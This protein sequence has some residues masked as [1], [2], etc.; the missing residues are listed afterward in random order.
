MKYPQERI[1]HLDKEIETVMHNLMSFRTRIG[2]VV[3]FGPFIVFSSVLFAT[4]GKLKMPS[5]GFLFTL[6][7]FFAIAAYLTMAYIAFRIDQHMTVQCDRWRK[8]IVKISKE[9]E[10]DENDLVFTHSSWRVYLF[11][12]PLSLIAFISIAYCILQILQ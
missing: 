2:F 5:S 7:V 11:M 12:F 8:A 10:P 4:S 6:G 1:Q 9:E 3:L